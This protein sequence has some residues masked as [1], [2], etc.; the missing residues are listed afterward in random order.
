MRKS[1][2]ND[3][4]PPPPGCAKINVNTIYYKE[5]SLLTWLPSARMMM[6]KLN[7]LA[8]KG[9]QCWSCSSSGTQQ[10]SMMLEWR[11]LSETKAILHLL[12]NV[13]SVITGFTPR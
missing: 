3:C 11:V 1:E 7:G 10:R 8:A 6:V 12:C 9:G 13:Q 4:I 2:E 5:T